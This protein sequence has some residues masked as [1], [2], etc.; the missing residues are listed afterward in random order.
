LIFSGHCEARQPV[1]TLGIVGT[2]L[3]AVPV[4]A[5]SAA[6]ALGGAFGW[7]VGLAQKPERAP[8][9]YWTIAAATFSEC[10]DD[11]GH[12]PRGAISAFPMPWR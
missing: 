4:L 2:G 11:I 6:Y 3:L 1:R 7:R 8:A 12:G 5:A 10:R 9:F